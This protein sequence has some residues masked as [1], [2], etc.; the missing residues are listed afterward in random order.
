MRWFDFLESQ[1]WWFALSFFSG[2][3][4]SLRQKLC[5]WRTDSSCRI[6][7]ESFWLFKASLAESKHRF[8]ALPAREASF[9][10]WEFSTGD[11]VLR[12]KCAQSQVKHLRQDLPTF[13]KDLFLTNQYYF[14]A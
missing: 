11:L 2:A 8:H 3:D 7:V 10:S 14:R 4:V 1:A 5:A 13:E 9:I 12:Y 6:E